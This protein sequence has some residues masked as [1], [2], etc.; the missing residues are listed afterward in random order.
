MLQL[1]LLTGMLAIA[2][3]AAA[4]SLGDGM[5]AYK[6]GDYAEAMRLLSPLA[7]QSNAQAQLRLGT[8][9]YYGQGIP[10]DEKVAVEWL[11]RA[12]LQGNRDAMFELGNAYLLGHE[13]P[14]LIPEPDR[15]AALWYFRAANAGHAEAQYQLGLL[16]LAGKGVVSSRKEAVKWFRKAA[17]QGHTEAKRAIERVNR[18]K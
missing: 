7:E 15:E 5:R 13:A 12:A 2:L 17:A 4:D 1:L 14:K 16:F 10:E 18:R 11:T 9:Y 8:M 6:A 3:P